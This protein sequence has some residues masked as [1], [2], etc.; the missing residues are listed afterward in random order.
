VLRPPFGT[1]PGRGA[2][3]PKTSRGTSSGSPRAKIGHCKTPCTDTTG[4][5]TSTFGMA[6][7][8]EYVDLWSEVALISLDNEGIDDISWKFCQNGVCS[9]ASAY[10]AQFLGSTLATWPDLIWKTW[11]PEKCKLFAWLVIKNR[12]WTA[13]RLAARGWDHNPACL[14]CRTQPETAHH[15]LVECRRYSRRIWA[16]VASW[17]GYDSA[18]PSGWAQTSRST[19]GGYSWETCRACLV[20]ASAL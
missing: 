18:K 17:T 13:D 4:C 11:A 7:L 15:L 10:K 12:Q 1:Q 3:S 16:A 8:N 19:T 6:S 20:K 14:L 2:G 5:A 9:A